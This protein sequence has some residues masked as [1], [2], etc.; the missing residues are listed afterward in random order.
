[1]S[2]V[3]AP[4][5]CSFSQPFLPAHLAALFIFCVCFAVWLC[6][7]CGVPGHPH[8]WVLPGLHLQHCVLPEALGSQLSPRTWVLLGWESSSVSPMAWAKGSSAGGFPRARLC[9]S[10]AA[11]GG[12]SCVWTPL[13]TCTA[14]C[15]QP[16]GSGRMGGIGRVEWSTGLL[17]S[18]PALRA[19]V[20]SNVL[21]YLPAKT[22]VSPVFPTS[23]RWKIF[24]FLDLGFCSIR[25]LQ[26]SHGWMLWNES[27]PLFSWQSSR[28]CCG[29]WWS[30]LGSVW[31][32]W[33]EALA[34][35]S[36]SLLLLPWRWQFSWSWRACLLS[37]MLFAC[38]GELQQCSEIMSSAW[39]GDWCHVEKCTSSTRSCWL[40]RSEWGCST[41]VVDNAVVSWSCSEVLEDHNSSLNIL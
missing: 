41:A 34:F 6:W 5:S 15:W 37:S 9:G 23:L 11:G 27:S 28:R 35:S 40:L 25:K 33:L 32:V 14:P 10:G 20:G 19:A 39:K 18:G 26:L 22:L 4:G 2:S 30:T 13:S 17:S 16:P 29:P 1:M 36:F 31:G 3:V 7:H 8:H 21:T 24:F 38:T 12:Q